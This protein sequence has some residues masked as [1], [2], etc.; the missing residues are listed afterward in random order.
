MPHARLPLGTLVVLAIVCPAS[1]GELETLAWLSGCWSNPEAEAGSGEYWQPL[2]GGTLLGVGR[3][4]R[5]GRTVAYEFLRLHEDEQGRVVYTAI[6]SRQKE[7]SFMASRVS[8]SGATFENPAHDFPQKITYTKIG[9]TG[10]V[11]RIEG[12][13]HGKARRIE[14]AFAR[15]PCTN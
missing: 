14:F 12:E 13:R 11:V 4:I 5:N 9:G 3:T 15:V 2:A 8:E 7:T 10:M 1:A 6:P